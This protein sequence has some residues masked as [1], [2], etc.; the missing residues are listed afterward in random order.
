MK[1]EDNPKSI[2]YHVKK[3]LQAN[4]ARL[5][6]KVVIDLPAG[7][8]ITSKQLLDLGAVPYPFDLFPEY[9]QFPEMHCQRAD[10]MQGINLDDK[11]A[12]FVI[13]QEGIE[14]FSDQY[15]AFKEFN[16]VLK[17]GG[18]LILTT[19]NYSNI[20]SKMSYFLAETERFNDMM[21][22]NEFDSVWLARPEI[23]Q[24]IYF[25][26]IF[27]LGIQ[28]LRVLAKLC[29]FKIKHIQFTRAK[30]TSLLL[31][32][33]FY[34]FIWLSN[35]IAYQKNLR[36]NKNYPKET[37]KESYQEIF[38]L[39]I[40]WKILID[41]HLF[42]EFEKEKDLQEVVQHLQSVHKDFGIT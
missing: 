21:P 35:W 17:K 40:N 4:Q 30:S 5:K 22:P 20:R 1:A 26:H 42:V 28:K 32:P 10:I 29:G 33:I 36:K 31:L 9:F 24:E 38:R 39:N 16:R 2:K 41:G 23:S 14:H 12:D 27:L 6:E 13:C 15:K 34:P 19:P 25:G 37:L 7:N 8:G 18:S 3:Y 11:F